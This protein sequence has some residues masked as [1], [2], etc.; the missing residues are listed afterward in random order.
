MAEKLERVSNWLVG[1]CLLA[2]VILAVL[3]LM[4]EESVPIVV[5]GIIGGIAFGA[6]G[7]IIS[8]LMGRGKK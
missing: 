7:D 4:L 8:V 1:F 6:D 2:L 5:Y 3:D